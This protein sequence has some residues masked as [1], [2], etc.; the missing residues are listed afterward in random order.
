MKKV[1]KICGEEVDENYFVN[2]MCIHCDVL[3]I[4]KNKQEG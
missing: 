4:L 1:C 2:D 3:R